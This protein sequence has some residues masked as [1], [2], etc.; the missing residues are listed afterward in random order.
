LISTDSTEKEKQ[1]GKLE[2]QTIDEQ[3]IK[4]LDQSFQQNRN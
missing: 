3:K 4:V 1:K 2:F